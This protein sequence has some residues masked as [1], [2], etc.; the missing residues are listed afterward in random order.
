MIRTRLILKAIPAG[1]PAVRLVLITCVACCLHVSAA[2]AEDRSPQDDCE[3]ILPASALELAS[4]AIAECETPPKY[5]SVAT[6]AATINT[7]SDEDD[8][9]ELPLCEVA[10]SAEQPVLPDMEAK[11]TWVPQG[12]IPYIGPRTPDSQKDR[13]IG[14]PLEDNGWRTNPFS[15]SGFSGVTAGGALVPGHVNQQASYYGGLNIGWD[16]DHFWGI[17][18]RL[19]FGALSLTDGSH[20][21]IDGNNLSVTGEYR[22]MYYPLGDARWRP[23]LTTGLGWSD[24]YFNDDRG[25]KRL[26][27]VGM[28]PFGLGIKYL[29]H[30]HLALRV[31]LIDEL[32]FGTG[33]LSTFH[34]V[35]LT[36]G[37]EVRYG[38]RLFKWPWHHA[39]ADAN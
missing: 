22:L 18:K 32:T 6:D 30:E 11:K 25:D 14:R 24:F 19:G 9:F 39:D 7:G 4:Q 37:L 13:G 34:Y 5:L 35:A 2:R 15:I 29:Q 27:T 23:F 28:V 10:S 3:V 33:A 36:A 21:A 8:L 12:V 31:D 1:V 38:R 17:E 20:H 16:Y 26:D